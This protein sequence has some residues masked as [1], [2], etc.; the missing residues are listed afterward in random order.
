ML[1]SVGFPWATRQAVRLRVLGLLVTLALLSVS[2]GAGA[3]PARTIRIGWLSP[4]STATHGPFFD[5]FRQSLQELGYVG[6]ANL[7]IESRWAEGK[8]DRLPSLA[9][10]LAGLRVDVIVAAGGPAIRASKQATTAIPIV[11]AIGADPVATGLVTPEGNVTGLSYMPGE[12]AVRQLGI[13]KEVVPKISRVAL[14]WSPANPV[15]VREVEDA[16]RAL[17]M[18]LQ[19]L[20]ARDPNEIDSAF[21]AMSK[22]QADAVIVSAATTFF[23]HRTRIA[24]L[25]A[26]RQL[27]S[28][29]PARGHA[30]AG[31]LVSYGLILPDLYRR[32]W[33]RF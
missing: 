24:D 25:A 8:L 1:R 16:A 10:E 33:T 6:G 14:L 11:M 32:A 17:G 4:G 12:L 7:A 30:E 18:R 3:Q 13:L 5:A 29:Y 21:T 22:E 31:G 28:V 23:I 19:P 15:N 9:A 20:E 26:Q 27:P 2:L